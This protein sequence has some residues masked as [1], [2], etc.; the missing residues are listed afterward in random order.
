MREI[1]SA[2]GWNP[3]K[4]AAGFL[5]EAPIFGHGTGSI[6]ALYVK[7]TAGKTSAAGSATSNPH[8]QTFGVAI[9]LGLVGA[10]ELWA[11]WIANLLLFRG[12]GLA[13]WVRLVIVV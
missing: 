13:E 5:L 8:N 2:S 1:R 6:H 3:G 7:L 9:Q 10:F 4:K 11:M 12:N